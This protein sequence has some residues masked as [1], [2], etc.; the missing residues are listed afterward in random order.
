M[1]HNML[2]RASAIPA[3][4]GLPTLRLTKWHQ[5]SVC[6][7]SSRS[8]HQMTRNRC[9]ASKMPSFDMLETFAFEMRSFSLFPVALLLL[10]L[11]C[12]VALPNKIS[13]AEDLVTRNVGCFGSIVDAVTF[14]SVTLSRVYFSLLS[15]TPKASWACLRLLPWCVPYVM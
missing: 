14:S 15:P 13:D 1:S 7:S 6:S 9:Y 3:N 5:L 12:A 4:H 11:R 10:L 8:R 2:F